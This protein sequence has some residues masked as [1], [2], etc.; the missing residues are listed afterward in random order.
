MTDTLS[1]F[2]TPTR[3]QPPRLPPALTDD[4]PWSHTGRFGRMSYLGWSLV[5]TIGISVAFSILSSIL[6]LLGF[7]A[8]TDTGS[9]S[10]IGV[11][12]LVMVYLAELYIQLIFTIRR[13]HDLDKSGTLA[14]LLL[15]PLINFFF[16]LYLIFAPGTKGDNRFG[17]VR[18]TPTWERVCG[19]IYIIFVP[20]A[21]IGI[22]A[23]IAIP[24]YQE[25]AQRSHDAHYSAPATT[26]QANADTT[27][28]ATT[29]E[30]PSD[31]SAAPNVHPDNGS[32]S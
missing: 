29:A 1:P 6:A 2:D 7:A 27:P 23:A 11:L 26:D 30:A 4:K 19:F 14:L 17:P 8:A 3:P 12:P 21:I 9:F 13:L 22:L 25:Y 31:A 20:I 16:A 10:V 32:S 5:A 18:P 24:A 15:I 28:P